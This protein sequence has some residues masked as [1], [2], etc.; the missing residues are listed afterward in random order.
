MPSPPPFISLKFTYKA[1]KKEKESLLV[2]SHF[3][4]YPIRNRILKYSNNLKTLLH[5][6]LFAWLN[7]ITGHFYFTTTSPFYWVTKGTKFHVT[8]SAGKLT[9]RFFF[10]LI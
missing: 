5:F 6:H 8:Y 1:S 2:Y 7:Y 3:C 10:S 9:C 4:R